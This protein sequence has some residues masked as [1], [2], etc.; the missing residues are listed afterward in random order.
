MIL[1]SSPA[2]VSEFWRAHELGEPIGLRTS[3]TTTGAGRLI[4]RTTDSWVN[5]FDALARDFGL[6]S[7]TR[8]WIPGPISST[9]NLFAACLAE[10][11]GG[12]WGT[13]PEGKNTAQLTPATLQRLVTE[14]VPSGIENAIVAGDGLSRRLRDRVAEL[15]V[16]HYYGA[17]E[18]SLVAVGSCTDDLRL[19]EDVSAKLVGGVLWVRSPWRAMGYLYDESE[20]IDG[21]VELQEDADCFVS[22]GDRAE[23]DGDSLRLLG[24]PGAVTTAGQT[25]LLAPLREKFSR[26]ATGVFWL[27]GLDN[28]SIGEVLTMICS[29]TDLPIMRGWA[30]SNLKG[31]DRPRRWIACEELPLT[32]AGKVDEREIRKIAG[33]ND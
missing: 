26:L 6:D 11:V 2:A 18:L 32:P 21:L 9:M 19:F 23:L 10:H 22:V 25:V 15:A 12:S 27:G 3:G 1:S 31:A 7:S 20:E 33:R 24:R 29:P 5:S 4:V 13:T 16:H 30:R 17:A 8:M 28:E 14:E